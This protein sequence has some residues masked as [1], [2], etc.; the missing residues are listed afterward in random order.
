MSNRTNTTKAD[1]FLV[2]WTVQPGENAMRLD[3]FLKEKYRR[4]SREYL[5]KAIKEGRVTLNH[6]IAKPSRLLRT[7]DKVYVLSV[8]KEE[9]E[10]DFNYKILYEDESILVVDKPG[11]LPVHPSGRYFFNTLLTQLQVV[12]E[13]EVDQEK[14]FH[15]V[16]RVDRETSGVLVMAKTKEAAASL[17][18]QFTKRQTEKEYLAIVRGVLK[19]DTYSINAALA[20]DPRAEIS[21]KMHV[22]ELGA[23]GNPL[24]VPKQE[25]MPASTEIEVI[26]RLKGYSIVRCK[27]HTGRQHQ[28]R[29]HLDHIG[30]PI[31]GDKLYGAPADLFLKNIMKTISLEVAPGYFLS[32]H[33]LH[34]AKLRL[35]HPATGKM[36]QFESSFPEELENFLK[37]VRV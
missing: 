36:M 27:P 15:I 25:M 8:K 4:L 18:D 6:E 30:Y 13:N 2:T 20:K 5:Q 14:K 12:N 33:A 16:H 17:V 3:L 10:V 37:H 31:I 7:G 19:K 21:I 29:V 35:K 9:P 28:I 23:D 24:Y 32:R 11:N 1:S 22:V 34:A 26:E